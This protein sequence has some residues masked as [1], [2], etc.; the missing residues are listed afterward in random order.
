MGLEVQ[1][2]LSVQLLQ[3]GQ[4]VLVIRQDL[5]APLDRLVLCFLLAQ[6]LWM[7]VQLRRLILSDLLNQSALWALV[8]QWVQLG[9]QD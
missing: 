8:G 5:V 6:V 9:R 2:L 1:C 3:L 4:L 7:L